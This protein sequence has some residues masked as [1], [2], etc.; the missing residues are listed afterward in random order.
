MW[1]FFGFITFTVFAISYGY[2]RINAR[3]KGVPGKTGIVKYEYKIERGEN[4]IV[5][6]KIGIEAYGDY[7]F[8]L[9]RESRFDRWC[10]KLGVV[11]EHQ[12]GTDEF[13]KEIYIISDDPQ[14]CQALSSN[15]KILNDVLK[16]FRS[17]VA[18]FCHLKEMRYNNEQ[19]WLS[20]KVDPGFDEASIKWLAATVAP[21]LVLVAAALIKAGQEVDKQRRDP[22]VIKAAIILAISTGLVIN[23]G[24]Q[25]LWIRGGG[26]PITLDI[27]ALLWHSVLLGLTIVALLIAATFYIIGRSSRTH[28]VLI[29]IVL[30]GTFGA[31]ATC[32]VEL[33]DLNIDSD[34]SV[35][36]MHVVTSVDKYVSS[37][38]RRSTSYYLYVEDWTKQQ[39]T[40]KLKVGYSIYNSISIG[41]RVRIMERSGFFGY[42]W[43]DKIDKDR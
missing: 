39:A 38:R 24:L 37:G 6:F 14:F 35:P 8:V 20:Y 40:I 27:S 15:I 29:E 19:L 23:G 36:A 5:G 12:V 42:R 7:D 21:R 30:V 17:G 16:L 13:D 31:M 9:K 3:W 32:F 2:K 33:R 41:D 10:K 4:N 25:I 22:F 28:L 26:P 43:I 34:R 1:F 11:I 18:D